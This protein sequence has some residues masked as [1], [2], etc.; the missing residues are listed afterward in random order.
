M[1]HG[2]TLSHALY[3][4][5]LLNSADRLSLSLP[6]RLSGTGG[7]GGPGLFSYCFP[8]EKQATKGG[9]SSVVEHVLSM[10]E[11][12][13]PSIAKYK[14]QVALNKDCTAD[15]DHPRIGVVFKCAFV[16]PTYVSVC[17]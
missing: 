2:D 16:L 12:L 17:C 11:A 9:V 4:F 5:S 6:S 15:G 7:Q 10:H 3:G 8:H 1:T 14:T 13:S